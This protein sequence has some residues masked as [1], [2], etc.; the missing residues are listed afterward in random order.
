MRAAA[1]VSGS[2][3][4]DTPRRLDLAEAFAVLD[5]IADRRHPGAIDRQTA[6]QRRRCL[7]FVHCSARLAHQPIRILASGWVWS[8]VRTLWRSPVVDPSVVPRPL[9]LSG[10]DVLEPLVS[11]GPLGSW[12]SSTRGPQASPTLPDNS[13]SSMGQR[14]GQVIRGTI[15]GSFRRAH[16]GSTSKKYGDSL[17]FSEF[18]SRP[19]PEDTRMPKNRRSSP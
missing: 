6:S 13:S 7:A 10:S 2:C 1:D 8:L 4:R 18:A 17:Q 12:S 9:V 3:D 11:A 19:V 14:S 15:L 16:E 5:E